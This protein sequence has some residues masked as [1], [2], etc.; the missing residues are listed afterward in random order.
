MLTPA[1]FTAM[2]IRTT[3]PVRRGPHDAMSHRVSRVDAIDPIPHAGRTPALAPGP[4]PLAI[5][6]FGVN[7]FSARAR[8]RPRRRA[9]RRGRRRGALRRADGAARFTVDG[10][11]FDAPQGTL[12]VVPAPSHREATATEPGTTVLA[13]GGVPGEPFSVSAWEKR[14]LAAARKD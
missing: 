10:E 1:Q 14:E 12:V 3:K 8:G 13:V 5:G 6:A 7:A 4:R 9:A 2:T 11:A